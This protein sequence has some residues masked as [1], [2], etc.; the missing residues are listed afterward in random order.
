MASAGKDSKI[1]VWDLRMGK[2]GWTLYS[3]KNSVN[4]INYNPQGDYFV[5][6]GADNL[7]MVWKSNFDEDMRCIFLYFINYIFLEFGVD[8]NEYSLCN[9]SRK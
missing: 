2:L 6:G 3:H 5:S 7:V 8:E 1:K 9:S 4:S